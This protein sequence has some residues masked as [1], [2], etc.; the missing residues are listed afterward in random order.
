MAKK[1][2]LFVDDDP[3]LLGGLQ[4]V[5]AKDRSRWDMTFALGGQLALDEVHKAPF[6]LVVSDM[7]MPGIDGATLL[8]A[9]KDECP[10]TVRILLSG[11]ADQDTIMRVLPAAHQLLIK[12]C[13]TRTL[14]A[15]L[16]HSL[17][18]PST[19]R[20]GAISELLCSIDKL[21][22]PPSVYFD[23]MRLLDGNASIAA[24]TEVVTRDPA[25][26]AKVL[27]L[28]NNAYFGNGAKTTSIRQAISLLGTQRLRYLAL[29][30]SVFSVTTDPE[31]AQSVRELQEQ[32]LRIA[33]LAQTFAE[34]AAR[35]E[36]FV[37]ALLHGV[38][39][40]V[41]ALGR[42]KELRTLA[43]RR[44][45]G[46]DART[47]ELDLFGVAHEELGARLLAIWGLPPAI[48]DIVLYQRDP[49]KA[50]PPIR[51][52]AGGLHVAA[53]MVSAR[54]ATPQL[55]TESLELAGCAPLVDG[56]RA[57]AARQA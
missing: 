21:P 10:S 4:N 9:I 3:A 39:L 54:G 28:V 37:S 15:A 27:Q 20:D 52:L 12:P 40:V 5:L 47:I 51:R 48:S 35:D 23:L 1:R 26:V 17:E 11:Y 44:D 50:P 38:G 19:A 18:R 46:E 33:T 41:L 53:A 49:A 36:A 14:R 29:T 7:R 6:D 32:S 45:A 13:D 22:T 16:E 25:L 34:P 56:W 8:L 24:V 2:I 43:R 55:N 42:P 30:A 31:C 57:A